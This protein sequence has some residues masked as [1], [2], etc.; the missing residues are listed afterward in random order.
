MAGR[1]RHK[2]LHLA[3]SMRKRQTP[4]EARLWSRLRNG[5]VEGVKFCRQ[6][7]IGPCI[8]DFVSRE[9]RL[10]VEA[11]GGQHSEQEEADRARAD[12]LEFREYQVLR[13]WNH[14]ILANTDAAIEVIVK[15][16]HWAVHPEN[17]ANSAE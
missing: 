3:R 15:A 5:G 8:V 1:A 16:L 4:A 17:P 14:A 2:N 12:F 11:D 9:A 10:V 6:I 13:F 7:P